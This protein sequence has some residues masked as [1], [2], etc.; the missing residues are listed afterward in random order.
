MP[1]TVSAKYLLLISLQINP[2]LKYFDLTT[3]NPT[4]L[5]SLGLDHYKTKNFKDA[6]SAWFE[7]SKRDPSDVSTH[8]STQNLAKLYL[9]TTEG[10]PQNVE[11]GFSL[12]SKTYNQEV[13][14]I[15]RVT[16]ALNLSD[17]LFRHNAKEEALEKLKEAYSQ[18]ISPPTKAAAACRLGSLHVTGEHEMEQKPRLARQLLNEA[19]SNPR[20]SQNTKSQAQKHLDVLDS[21]EM[22]NKDKTLWVIVESDS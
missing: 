12:L 11:L 22:A 19:I 15:S 18:N 20:A 16:A 17:I 3:L 2:M 1:T 6:E 9:Y 13:D 14:Q 4:E 21:R 7:A 8:R 5:Y 10:I